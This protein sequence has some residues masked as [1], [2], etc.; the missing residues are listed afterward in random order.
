M[1]SRRNFLL[2]ISSAG[3]GFAIGKIST[4]PFRSEIENISDFQIFN[5]N[6]NENFIIVAP[7]FTNRILI[8]QTLDN[9]IQEIESINGLHQCLVD[10]ERKIIF[11]IPRLG[12]KVPYYDLSSMKK[13]GDISSEKNAYFYGHGSISKDFKNICFSEVEYPTGKGRILILNLDN[14]KLVNRYSSGGIS[15]HECAFSNDGKTIYTANGGNIPAHWGSNDIKTQVQ[16]YV[17]KEAGNFSKINVHDGQTTLIADFDIQLG[18]PGHFSINGKHT[19]LIFSPENQFKKGYVFSGS[20]LGNFKENK[21]SKK[22]DH[23]R[24]QALSLAYDPLHLIYGVT[25]P[26]AELISFWKADSGKLI[27]TLPI[28]A[29]GIICLNPGYFIVNTMYNSRAILINIVNW[30]TKIIKGLKIGNGSHLSFIR[31]NSKLI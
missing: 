7:H 15:P 8:S 10:S 13:I 17:M 26:E 2:G 14:M 1:I 3:V 25:H 23:P 18:S 30:Q 5:A 28:S 22:I 24:G 21:F 27:K 20:E 12:D 31:N 4:N 16:A 29:K 9:R 19:A 11:A 6:D